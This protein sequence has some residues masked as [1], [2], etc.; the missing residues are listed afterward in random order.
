M[1]KSAPIPRRE[2]KRSIGYIAVIVSIIAVSSLLLTTQYW[3]VWPVII[4]GLLIAIG[5]LTTSKDPYQCPSCNKPFRI[6]ALQDFLAPHGVSKGE[7][8]EIYEWKLLKCHG[9]NKRQKCYRA[10]KG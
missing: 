10:E 2:I 4:I 8:G 9:C 7:N 3:F 6:T 5:Y 1:G